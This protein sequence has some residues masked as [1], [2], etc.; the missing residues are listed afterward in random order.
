MPW[1]P[2]SIEPNG[3]AVKNAHGLTVGSVIGELRGV[4][5]DQNHLLSGGKS[6]SRGLKVAGRNLGFRDTLVGKKTMGRFRIGPSWQTKWML[7]PM[8]SESCSKA[9]EIAC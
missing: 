3:R 5:E 9:F 6:I 7:S 8:P 2:I 1:L 4:M